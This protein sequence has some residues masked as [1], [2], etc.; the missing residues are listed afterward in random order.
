MLKVFFVF[1]GFFVLKSGSS[2]LHSTG[3]VTVTQGLL[4]LKKKKKKIKSQSLSDSPSLDVLGESCCRAGTLV[5]QAH[6]PCTNLIKTYSQETE[7]CKSVYEPRTQPMDRQ[8]FGK[9]EVS[10]GGVTSFMS[11]T[12]PFL[13]LTSK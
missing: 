1:R 12:E 9:D 10:A 6:R 4:F 11:K 2:L 3:A 13:S 8:D 7:F 5:I